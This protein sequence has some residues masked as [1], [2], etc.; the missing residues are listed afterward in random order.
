MFEPFILPKHDLP[1]DSLTTTIRELNRLNPKPG[2]DGTPLPEFW[3]KLKYRPPSGNYI[4]R[5][6]H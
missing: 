3:D 1:V 6:L 2:G 4:K 5:G